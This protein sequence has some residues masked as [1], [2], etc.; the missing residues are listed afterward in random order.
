MDFRDICCKNTVINLV[1]KSSF[2]LSPQISGLAPG[3]L[4]SSSLATPL[5]EGMYTAIQVNRI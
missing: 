5:G 3:F 4:Y 1:P 2:S